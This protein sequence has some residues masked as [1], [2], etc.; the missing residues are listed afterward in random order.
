ML[1]TRPKRI[2]KAGGSDDITPEDILRFQQLFEAQSLRSLRRYL[3]YGKRV[4]NRQ[5]LGELYHWIGKIL[6]DDGRLYS[7]EERA[8]ACE[9]AAC[10]RLASQRSQLSG[11]VVDL[12]LVNNSPPRLAIY[13]QILHAEN[14]PEYRNA[15]VELLASRYK[16]HW[17]WIGDCAK[18]RT[19]EENYSIS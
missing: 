7:L 18:G 3:D 9:I 10:E 4:K 19:S 2:Y 11:P 8:M 17:S 12:V 5:G 13:R 15:W 14:A 16:K 1:A 6:L